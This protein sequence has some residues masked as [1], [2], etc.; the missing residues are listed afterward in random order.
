MFTNLQ[1][2]QCII[3]PEKTQKQIM[4]LYDPQQGDNLTVM[5]K[6]SRILEAN[7][8]RFSVFS[9]TQKLFLVNSAINHSCRPNCCW[10]T[11]NFSD[12]MSVVAMVDIKKDE[13]I[14]INYYFDISDT[15][16]SFCLPFI[17]RQAKILSMFRFTCVCSECLKV[18]QG[19][20]IYFFSFTE[21]FE[22]RTWS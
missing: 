18:K 9:N 13:E 16:G 4:S 17:L 6:L 5:A 15:R 11:S 19:V 1:L 7:S 20:P 8:C 14:S 21:I 3:V 22:L 12:I 2:N 10:K